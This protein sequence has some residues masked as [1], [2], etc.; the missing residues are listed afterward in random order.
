VE[1]GPPEGGP[2]LDLEEEPAAYA[3]GYHPGEVAEIA[4]R[5]MRT[6]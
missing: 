1:D 5:L 4:A 3:P 6:A 2:I